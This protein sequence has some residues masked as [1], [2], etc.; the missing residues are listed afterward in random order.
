MI[1]VLR[2]IIPLLLI[3]ATLCFI[4]SNSMKDAEASTE[5]SNQVKVYIEEHYDVEKEPVK[6]IY[7]NLRKTAHFGEFALLGAELS[8]YVFL[9][10]RRRWP[11]LGLSLVFAALCAM[12]DEFLQTFS[13]GRAPA[14]T[15]VGIDTLGALDGLAF[16]SVLLFIVFRLFALRNRREKRNNENKRGDPRTKET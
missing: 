6:L 10:H 9:N 5:Q 13:A 11:T 7:N 8:L 12:L 1:S 15:D 14:W 2:R 4:W 16:A 3:A